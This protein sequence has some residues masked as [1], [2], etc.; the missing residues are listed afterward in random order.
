[1]IDYRDFIVVIKVELLIFNEGQ[2]P[3]P[4]KKEKRLHQTSHSKKN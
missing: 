3:H 2:F 1:M 4:V